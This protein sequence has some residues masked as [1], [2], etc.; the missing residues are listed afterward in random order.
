MIWSNVID[1]QGD[2][3]TSQKFQ[4]AAGDLYKVSYKIKFM[5]KKQA[6]DYSVLPLEGLW[7]TD[8]NKSNL[9]GYIWRKI[10]HSSAR[11]RFYYLTS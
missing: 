4:D 6:I 7:W 9:G 1:G 10:N 2:P 3:N 5:L 8:F 11:Q